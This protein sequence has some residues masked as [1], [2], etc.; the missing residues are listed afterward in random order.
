MWRGVRS[1]MRTHIRVWVLAGICVR[2]LAPSF[3]QQ[4]PPDE[5]GWAF[6]MPVGDPPAGFNEAPLK[7]VPGS[8]KTYE[9]VRIDAFDPPDWFPDEH[10]PMPEVVRHGRG[11][12]VMAC[13]YCHL[14]S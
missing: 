8:S 4:K 7:H 14:A 9:H 5:L 2:A 12:P 1:Q 10:P 11:N 3:P 6:P 13:S